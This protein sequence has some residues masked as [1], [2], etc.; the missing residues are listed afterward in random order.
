MYRTDRFLTP[1]SIYR[2]SK[3]INH[4][5][6]N[7]LDT[8]LVV[9]DMGKM[10]QNQNN[11]NIAFDLLRVLSLVGVIVMHVTSGISGGDFSVDAKYMI[12]LIYNA[13]FHYGVPIFVMISG[14]LFLAPGK[15]IDIK[16]LWLHNI[17]RMIIVYFVWSSVYGI[18]DYF[19]YKAGWK[20]ILW[21]IVNSRDH[22]WFL[23]MIIGIYM[24]IPIISVWVKNATEKNLRYFLLLFIVFQIICETIKV[25][26]VPE[27][28]LFVLNL[29]RIQLVCSYIGYF[30]LG[31]YIVH[32][33]V[34]KKYLRYIYIAG[35]AAAIMSIGGV[36]AISKYNGYASFGIVDSFSVLTFALVVAVFILVCRAFDKNSCLVAD[37]RDSNAVKNVKSSPILSELGKDSL[38][39]YLCHI[40]VIEL[41]MKLGFCVDTLPVAIGIPIY[42]IVVYLISS[43]ISAILRRIPLLGRFIC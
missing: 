20:Y 15:E 18:Y 9:C 37:D 19:Q 1:V 3:S 7:G 10:L 43:F 4:W 11:R 33:G 6:T 13:P 23:P 30:I 16:R 5:Q 26:P 28:M 41:L 36:L 35:V 39:A 24:I 17:L 31:Y 22:L 29:R 32:I 14:A 8:G 27:I 2:T 34:R 12:T 21:E 25:I 40:A 42:V 38:G